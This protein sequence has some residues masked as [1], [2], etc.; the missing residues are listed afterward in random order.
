MTSINWLKFTRVYSTVS[1]FRDTEERL[2]QDVAGILMSWHLLYAQQKTLGANTRY[3]W[4]MQ[5]RTNAPPHT[6]FK[7]YGKTDWS[8]LH[9]SFIIPS[10]CKRYVLLFIFFGGGWVWVGCVWGVGWGLLL[11]K[12]F[13][14][15]S[16]SVRDAA[17]LNGR[18]NCSG[19]HYL[20]EGVSLAGRQGY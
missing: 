12:H 9:A 13:A 15:I 16:C 14:V 6:Y 10:A 11:P 7:A 1:D 5:T 17:Q 4:Y 20:R 18:Q 2:Q 19:E 8:A 3:A